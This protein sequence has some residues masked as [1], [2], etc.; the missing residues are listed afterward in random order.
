MTADPVVDN[1]RDR[2]VEARGREGIGKSCRKSAVS[3]TGRVGEG[4][5]V[6]WNVACSTRTITNAGITTAAVDEVVAIVVGAVIAVVVAVYFSVVAGTLSIISVWIS[7]GVPSILFSCGL[8]F[9]R[10]E[11]RVFR[12]DI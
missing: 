1:P 2:L 9:N 5:I 12:A 4:M 7:G 3:F 6:P 10:F 11:L 8:F